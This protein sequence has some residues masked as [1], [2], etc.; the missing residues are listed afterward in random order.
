[1]KTS[2][3]LALL[4]TALG[5][6]AQSPTYVTVDVY[7]SCTDTT[8]GTDTITSTIVETTCPLCTG[9]STTQEGQYAHTTVYTT[10]WETLCSTGLGPATY[11]I[12]ESCTGATPSWNSGMGQPTYIPPGYT[13]TVT[14]CTVCEMQPTVTMTVPCEST[15]PANPTGPAHN[16]AAPGGS[17]NTANE[18]PEPTGAPL[19]SPGG[20]PGGSPAGQGSG[21]AAP[22]GQ[23][24]GEGTTITT[25]V[26]PGTGVCHHSTTVIAPA[27]SQTTMSPY[28]GAAAPIVTGMA[29]LLGG[30]LAVAG[31]ILI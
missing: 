15:P 26:C 22:G 25:T 19:G 9:M 27:M 4:T 20:S 16:G 18:T 1:M 11:T 10:V 2:L 23:A 13:T 7:E 21:G 24:M 6:A 14:V 3:T 31:A 29:N 28:T 12:T 5:V 17:A 8:E 30:A